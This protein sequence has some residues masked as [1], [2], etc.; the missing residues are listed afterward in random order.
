METN[1]TFDRH[2]YDYLFLEHCS[3]EQKHSIMR[4]LGYEFPHETSEIMI[5]INFLK[6]V[7][8]NGLFERFKRLINN[9]KL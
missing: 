3:Q 8:D 6:F 5:N 7:E 4:E 1:K 2:K 9:K